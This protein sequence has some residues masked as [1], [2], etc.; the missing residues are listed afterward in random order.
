MLESHVRPVPARVA[1]EVQLE[2]L[3]PGVGFRPLVQGL[4]TR[5]GFGGMVTNDTRGVLIEVEGCGPEV[6][7]FLARLEADAPP[8]A[9]L[10]R[11]RVRTIPAR[12]RASFA[13]VASRPGGARAVAVSPD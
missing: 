8:L 5:L 6:T 13:I 9:A 3:V 12:G 4:A 7:R 2:G 1:R 11:M 10:T